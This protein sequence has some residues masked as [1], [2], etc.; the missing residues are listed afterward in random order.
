MRRKK[1]VIFFLV[2]I[3]IIAIAFIM[4]P[5]TYTAYKEC[6]LSLCDCECYLQG[7]TPEEKE[8]RICGEDCSLYNAYGCKYVGLE[9]P[10]NITGC[11]ILNMAN[12][13]F[14]QEQCAVLKID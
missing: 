1:F 6:V 8:G 4:Q 5:T 7:E 13:F 12:D 14:V 10:Y 11:A 9:C 2:S 3:A